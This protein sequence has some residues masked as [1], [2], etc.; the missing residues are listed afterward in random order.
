MSAQSQ[1][2]Y[3]PKSAKLVVILNIQDIIGHH[4]NA[5]L[6]AEDRFIKTPRGGAVGT[7][8]E[9][10]TSVYKGVN[11]AGSCLLLQE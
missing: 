8:Q 11:S 10:S 5:S 6:T 3:V 2:T 4:Y 7:G 1:G 9:K